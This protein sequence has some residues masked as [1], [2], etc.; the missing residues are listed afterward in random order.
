MD[1]CHIS[2]RTHHVSYVVSYDQK[3]AKM[4][5]DDAFTAVNDSKWHE[6]VYKFGGW[7]RP[8]LSWSEVSMRRDHIQCYLG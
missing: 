3:S 1:E 5:Y 4:I 6:P 8:R 2:R 7:I